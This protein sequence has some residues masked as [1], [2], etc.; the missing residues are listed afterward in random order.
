VPRKPRQELA[1]GIFHVWARRVDRR[2]IF[3][4]DQDRQVYLQLLAGAV[5]RQGWLCL[6]YCLMSNHVHLLLETPEPN[7]AQGMQRF[8]GR[9]AELFNERHGRVGHLFERRYGSSLCMEPAQFARVAAYIAANPVTAG[10]CAR[11]ED[12]PWSSY[13][14]TQDRS[15]PAW[16]AVDRL[17]ALL[18]GRTT[19]IS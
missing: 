4:D 19:L 6:A 14:G 13:G 11:A 5:D 16:V 15:A 18:G 1:G 2:I 17:F 9:Y 10:L 8:H 3:L 12:W 7:L